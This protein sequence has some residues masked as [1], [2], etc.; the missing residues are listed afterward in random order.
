M[1]LPLPS[2]QHDCAA[3][4]GLCC[5]VLPFDAEQGF[6]FDKGAHTPC[7]HLQDD[8]GCDIHK[9]LAANGF[10]GCIHYS[11]H[12]AG[13]RATRMFGESNWRSDPARKSEIYSA[14]TQLQKLHGLQHLLVFAIT[15]VVSDD[16]QQ[17]LLAEQQ[18]LEQLCRQVELQ[19]AVDIEAAEAGTLAILRQLATEPEIVA[20]R[21]GKTNRG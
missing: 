20:L 5:V 19:N 4:S 16:W 21:T 1:S 2:L 6:G 3:C 17:R 18:R 12:G 11:C 14:F 7:S 10:S 13:Q 9:S 15:K 8:F